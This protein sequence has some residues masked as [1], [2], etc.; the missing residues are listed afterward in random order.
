MIPFFY[1]KEMEE[2]VP[3]ELNNMI[4]SKKVELFEEIAALRTNYLTVVLEDIYQEH[5]ASAVLRTCDCFGIQE[6]RTIKKT[7]NTRFKDTFLVER[8]DGSTYMAMAAG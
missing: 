3:I 6:L 7:T 8:D 1:F 4:S 2:D 5:N